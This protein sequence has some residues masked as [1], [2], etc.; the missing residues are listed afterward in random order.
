MTH[1]D[2]GWLV[3]RTTGFVF[4]WLALSII[5]DLI[6]VYKTANGTFSLEIAWS[7]CLVFIAY[8]AL[9]FYFLR[10]G[11]FCHRLICYR[12][13]ARHNTSSQRRDDDN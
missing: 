6:D 12:A 7:Q 5:D 2:A 3:L 10:H 13:R 4:V 9:A 11:G 1:Q 8:G